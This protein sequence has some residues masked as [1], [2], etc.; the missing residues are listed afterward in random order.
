MAIPIAV[1]CRCNHDLTL[2]GSD[3][4]AAAAAVCWTSLSSRVCICVLVVSSHSLPTTSSYF[5]FDAYIF[6]VQHT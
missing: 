2:L 1:E 3:A 5:R 4:A 6:N